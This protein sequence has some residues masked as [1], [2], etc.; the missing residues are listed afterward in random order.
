[1]ILFDVRKVNAEELPIV[2]VPTTF[3]TDL[4]NRS[5]QKNTII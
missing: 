4:H 1:M 5:T 2:L 3:V